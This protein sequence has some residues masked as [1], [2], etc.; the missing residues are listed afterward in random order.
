M[1]FRTDFLEIAFTGVGTEGSCPAEKD[2]AG[3]WFPDADLRL[4]APERITANKEFCDCTFRWRFSDGD[5][6]GVSLGKT[7]P[8]IPTDVKTVYP[9]QALTAQNAA[10]PADLAQAIIAGHMRVN[11][12][13]AADICFDK[14]R[15]HRAGRHVPRHVAAVP[16]RRRAK[17]GGVTPQIRNS[18][19]PN[20]MGLFY[21]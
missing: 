4:R 7:L 8:A 1:T 15:L 11:A 12:D 20:G 18:P 5:A 3:C 16:P 21:T 2:N 19:M 6:H 10:T 13:F 14:Q 17:T 9:R